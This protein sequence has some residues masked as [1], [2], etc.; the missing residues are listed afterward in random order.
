MN[1]KILRRAL[2][3]TWTSLPV[4]A[5]SQNG[6]SQSSNSLKLNDTIRTYNIVFDFDQ[7][8]ICQESYSYLDSLAIILK[9]QDSL[10]LEV[11]VHCDTRRSAMYSRCLTC[12]R[13][14]AIKAYLIKCGI[15]ED[16]MVAKGYMD[17]NP[18][19]P[20]YRIDKMDGVEEQEKA[21][22]INRRVEFVVLA[23]DYFDRKK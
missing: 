10:V 13:A 16:R 15:Q 23:V 9:Q 4:L 14:R 20:Q 12:G 6:S 22:Q 19:I 3:L 8:T 7:S 2:I 21:H 18:I 17:E 5:Y 1:F 11:D